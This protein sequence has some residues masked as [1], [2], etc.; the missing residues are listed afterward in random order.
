MHGRKVLIEF[1]RRHYRQA[2]RRSVPAAAYPLGMKIVA[3]VTG[4][5]LPSFRNISPGAITLDCIT[6]GRGGDG[7]VL[8]TAWWYL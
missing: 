7:D 6:C 8:R 4:F 1:H 3:K 2:G 5:L